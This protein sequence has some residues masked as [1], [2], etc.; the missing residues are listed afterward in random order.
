VLL[1]RRLPIVLAT[2]KFAPAIH[3][4]REA[5]F[6]GWFGP[7]GVGALFYYTVA[8][9]QFAEDGPD[10]HARSVV[11]P[12]VYFMILASVLVHGNTIPMF[13]LGSFATRTLTRTS[14]SSSGTN[15]VSR[16]PKLAFGTDIFS[17]HSKDK[18]NALATRDG[19]PITR[20]ATE[21]QPNLSHPPK[22]TAI[23]IVTPDDIRAKPTMPHSESAPNISSV[24]LAQHGNSDASSSRLVA[25]QSNGEENQLAGLANRPGRNSSESL[26]DII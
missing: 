5:L 22:Q 1:L 2:Y 23:T 16:L 13:Y 11:K 14:F 4:F 3:N 25:K 19:V 24:M 15:S 9:E 7:I 12:I 17:R 18:S 20:D 26:D 21:F 8:I 10:A 6:T